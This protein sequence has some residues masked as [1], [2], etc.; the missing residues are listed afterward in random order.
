MEKQIFRRALGT[1]LDLIELRLSLCEFGALA[2]SALHPGWHC[3]CRFTAGEGKI[4]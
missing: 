3:L 2:T 1:T 4:P